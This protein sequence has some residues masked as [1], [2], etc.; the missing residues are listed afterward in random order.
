MFF[1]FGTEAKAKKALRY[2]EERLAEAKVMATRNKIKEMITAANDYDGFMAMVNERVEEAWQRGPSDNISERVALATSKHLSIL[3]WV[4]DHVPDEAKEAIARAREASMNGQVNALRALARNRLE[5]AFNINAAA[6][7][8]RMERALVRATA[9]LTTDN[10]STDNVTN[11]INEA[12]DYAIRIAEL[13]DEMLAIAEEKGLDITALQQRLAHS[14]ANRLEV[15]SSVYEKVPETARP[16]IE[17]A[18]ENSVRKYERAVEKLEKVNALDEATANVTALQNIPLKVREKLQLRVTN[19]VK[20]SN[21]VSGNA[22]EPAR[23]QAEVKQK[24]REQTSNV[25]SGG[26]GK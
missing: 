25:N 4:E 12:L 26:Q 21:N 16:A 10:T 2:A 14:T 22:T 15:L 24:I 5:N 13:E 17:R 23:I 3:D 1:T 19:Q 20:L 8:G 6:I 11:D 9:N 7:E 18:I